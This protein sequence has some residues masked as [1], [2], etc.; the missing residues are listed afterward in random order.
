VRNSLENKRVLLPPQ[1][2]FICGCK[3]ELC[4]LIFYFSFSRY[5]KSTTSSSPSLICSENS[6]SASSALSTLSNLTHATIR[7][8]GA[9]SDYRVPPPPETV[10]V[11]RDEKSV[12][13]EHLT[14]KLGAAAR[15][16]V[17]WKFVPSSAAHA[18]SSPGNMS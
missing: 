7:H 10:G 3:S 14:I 18:S 12:S 15:I 8:T 1:Q 17:C 16:F 6:S 13:F 9:I 4:I 2:P 11:G 5:L